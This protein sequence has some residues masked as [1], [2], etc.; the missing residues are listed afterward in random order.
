MTSFTPSRNP[1]SSDLD[2]ILR[3]TEGLW[4]SLRKQ[5]IFVTGG[6]GFF[7]RWLLESF[8]HINDSLGIDARMVVLSR[9]PEAFAAKAPN[10]AGHPAISFVK[11]DVRT[12]TASEARSQ[13]GAKMPDRFGVVIHAATESSGTTNADNPSLTAETI[14]QGTRATLEFAVGTGAKRFL[15]TSSGAVYGRQPAE[16]THIPESY[17]GVASDRSSYGAAKYKAELLCASYQ[18]QHGLEPLIARC[19]AFVGPFLPLDAHFAIGNFILDAVRGGPIQV[20]GDGTPYR[21]YLYAADL[22]IWLWTILLRGTAGR[23]YNVGSE[24]AHTIADLAQIVAGVCDDKGAIVRVKEKADPSKSGQRY[25]PSCRRAAD[26]LGLA[27]RITLADGIRRTA[28]FAAE[29]FENS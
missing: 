25:V 2:H 12:F 22:A 29:V 1:L 24:D 16:M 9:N 7:G 26:E 10:L 23:A 6:T 5:A 21:S 17:I 11:G 27:Q 15:F 14:E 19:F 28:I 13:L 4:E 8:A 20:N 3:H 18:M